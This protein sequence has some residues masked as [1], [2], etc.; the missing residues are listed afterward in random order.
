MTIERFYA[1]HLY[2]LA[3]GKDGNPTLE[4]IRVKDGYRTCYEAK[5]YARS[6]KADAYNIQ[7][8]AIIKE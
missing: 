6:C 4:K 3:I 7:A 8:Y 5:K 1:A 2:R